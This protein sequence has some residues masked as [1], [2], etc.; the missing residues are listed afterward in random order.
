MAVMVVQSGMSELVAP[1][2]ASSLERSDMTSPLATLPLSICICGDAECVV[3]YGYCH[4]L[5]GG[6]TAIAT[7][8]DRYVH[9]ITGQPR[10]YLRHHQSRK[11]NAYLIG[12]DYVVLLINNIPATIFDKT[13]M[14]EVCA[15][16]WSNCAD[17]YFSTSDRDE[18]GKQ[19]LL[20]RLVCHTPE[21]IDTDHISGIKATIGGITFGM[22]RALKTCTTDHN[23]LTV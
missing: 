22:R 8:T 17:G 3:P 4:C 1:A 11:P 5:C 20:H 16:H 9:K 7:N 2:H 10:I 6:K 21:G 19:I 23:L 12:P 14:V 15:H 18:R 13:D